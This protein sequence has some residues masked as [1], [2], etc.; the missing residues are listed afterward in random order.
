MTT[1]NEK[2]NGTANGAS[3]NVH[4]EEI[5]RKKR[6]TASD[7]LTQEQQNQNSLV[8][9]KI[10][11]IIDDEFNLP[12][13]DSSKGTAVI[14]IGLTRQDGGKPPYD[15]EGRYSEAL[16]GVKGSKGSAVKALITAMQKSKD[17]ADIVQA[18]IEQYSFESDLDKSGIPDSLKDVLRTILS[19]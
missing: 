10:R 18:A 9:R 15:G 1:E 4:E 2:V 5:G 14:I 13:G 12:N 6:R 8:F 11:N 19:R 3:K 7:D 17:F 16:I